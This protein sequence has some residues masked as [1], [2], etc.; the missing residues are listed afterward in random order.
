MKFKDKVKDLPESSP[1][2]PAVRS[3]F[4]KSVNLESSESVNISSCSFKPFTTLTC[5][6]TSTDQSWLLVFLSHNK[7]NNQISFDL[8][9]ENWIV[10]KELTICPLTDSF[11]E[12][13]FVNLIWARRASQS[14]WLEHISVFN[15]LSTS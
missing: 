5:H 15:E 10:E 2:R 11:A 8:L 4:A 1:F 6:V 9:Y 13:P 7:S 3:S 12:K 14:S